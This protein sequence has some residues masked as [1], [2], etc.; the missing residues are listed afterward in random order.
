MDRAGTTGECNQVNDLFGIPHAYQTAGV[1]SVAA[2]AKDDD[3]GVGYAEIL[4]L[5]TIPPLGLSRG[6]AGLSHRR[7]LTQ[8]TL[9][10]PDAVSSALCPNMPRVRLP[11]VV[12]RSLLSQLET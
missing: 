11:L 6:V 5:F 10:W 3:G 2:S 9:R 1:Y 7:A 4:L 8:A 12:K